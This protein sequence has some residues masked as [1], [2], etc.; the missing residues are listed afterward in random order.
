MKKLNWRVGILALLAGF[1]LAACGP[2]ESEPVAPQNPTNPPGGGGT[3]PPANNAPT[4]NGTPSTSTLAGR[5]YN[6]FPGAND[7]D[8]DPLTFSATGLPAWARITAQTGAISGTPM[9]ADVGQTG[10]IV[11][12]VTDGKATASLPAFR[13]TVV[14]SVP[15][16]ASN[17]P[18]T[19]SG[20]PPATVVAGTAYSFTPTANDP[21]GNT[22]AF[23]ISGKP[24]WIAFSTATGA[25]TGTPVA[26]NIGTY[27][28]IVITVSDGV[29]SRS[30]PA[31]SISVTQGNT[32]TGTAS[33]SWTAPSQNTDGS[34]LTDLAGFRV[35][36]G[37][38]PTALNVLATVPGST[39]TG[40]VATQLATGTHYFAVAAYT[41]SGVESALSGVGSKTIP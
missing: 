14:T 9:E 21:D 39:S 33:L 31:F 16:P 28:N 35:Y 2:K 40:Y 30:L 7:T 32:N 20:T 37:T 19:I 1:A 23:S 36:H 29:V 15:P 22:L 24:G 10:D 6:F 27:T 12:S 17:N 25:L 8:S 13:I 11:V 18:P 3:P 41:N 38:S 5:A 4:I 26:A 34:A